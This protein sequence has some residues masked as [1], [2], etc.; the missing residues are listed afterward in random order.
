MDRRDH[1]NKQRDAW[2]KVNLAVED[3]SHAMGV[4]LARSTLCRAPLAME[5]LQMEPPLA[6]QKLADHRSHLVP[7]AEDRSL[8]AY[9]CL[10]PSLDL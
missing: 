7:L 5:F 3:E 4:Y 2:A 8:A 10:D 6:F 1:Q 9:H